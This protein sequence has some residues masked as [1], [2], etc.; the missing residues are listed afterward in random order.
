VVKEVIGSWRIVEMDLWDL[1][2]IELL[3]P[4][5]IEF[6]IDGTGRFRFIA[7]EG[8]I[9]WKIDQRREGRYLDFTWDGDDEGDPASGRGW[10]EV[11]RD[12]SL[13]GHVYFHL[14]DDSRFR[15]V[16]NVADRSAVR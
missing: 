3:G 12:G 15:A 10:I 13:L 8:F 2:A 14:G 11:D 5:F 1:D 6:N 4:A 9:D 16:R 7:V